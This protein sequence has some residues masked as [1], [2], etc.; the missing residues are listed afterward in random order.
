M[1]KTACWVSIL[2][3][4]LYSPLEAG[5][6]KEEK[7]KNSPHSIIN[8]SLYYPVSLHQSKYISTNLNLSLLYGHVGVV[9]G[10]DLSGGCSVAED[11]IQGLQIAGLCGISG[12]RV[13]GVQTSGLLSVVG[14]KMKGFQISGG[15]NVCGEKLEGVQTSGLFN[16]TGE[17]FKG[18][19]LSGLMNISGES[20]QGW[21]SSGLLNVVGEQFKGIQVSGLFNVVGEE[22]TGVQTTGLF[23]VAGESCRGLQIAGLFNV[24]GENMT[25]LQ[26]GGANV[27]RKLGGV[28]IGLYNRTQE[29][30]GFQL[31]LVNVSEETGG[32]PVGLV[33]VSKQ[34]G[35][36]RWVNWLSSLSAF[37]S[38]MK[39]K[40][41]NTYSLI[42]L[43]AL[44]LHQ[45][46]PR[47]LAWSGFY[48]ISFPVQK[49]YLN[50]DLGFM[51]MDNQ[52]FFRSQKGETDQKVGMIRGSLG[53]D[54][55]DQM[56]LFG[57]VGA[58]YIFP[59]GSSLSSGKWRA[60][61]FAGL[62]LF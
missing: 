46:I 8:F 10:L 53:I 38:G 54:L 39:F 55:S 16:V 17:D 11:E 26:L 30:E 21:Q 52:N 22:F 24:A 19:Q 47:S 13:T 36:I 28:Q 42:S 50:T 4:F 49:I 48:G 18:V 37:N 2:L 62:E 3:L 1:K 20:G 44:N 27:S 60:L 33:N 14:G 6:D 45:N 29:M 31:G 41:H 9:T 61:F 7:E 15:F 35:R 34:D 23:N 56:S 25:G 43:G 12:D 51:Y 32:L 57:G 5:N 59:S 58:A 40:I